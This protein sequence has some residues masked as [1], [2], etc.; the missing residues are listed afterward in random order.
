M[1]RAFV[2]VAACVG[3]V[4]GGAGCAPG[5]AFEARPLGRAIAE[6]ATVAGTS[7]GDLW[8]VLSRDEAGPIAIGHVGRD[9][10]WEPL[11]IR[12]V[13]GVLAMASPGPDETWVLTRATASGVPA[14][15]QVKPGGVVTDHTAELGTNIGP[16]FASLATLG[17]GGGGVFVTVSTEES[18]PRARILRAVDGR[19]VELTG[20]PM[21]AAALVVGVVGP[22]EAYFALDSRARIVRWA[23]GVWS[24]VPWTAPG[25]PSVVAAAPTG[26]VWLW[27]PG[28]DGSG[29]AGL[30][31][32]GTTFTPFSVAGWPSR[33]AVRYD[34]GT[35]VPLG[36]G[37]AAILAARS[38][39]RRVEL[40][41]VAISSDG[42]VTGDRRLASCPSVEACTFEPPAVLRFSDGTVILANTSTLFVGATFSL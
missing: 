29:G 21:A 38:E 5:E 34:A 39:A 36:G 16:T 3:V 24:D 37:R 9:Q 6:P 27:R 13:G 17:A 18:I 42:R 35:L 28:S 25:G 19:L 33:D 20:A 12:G 40:D 11:T 2:V 1:G 7:L 41:S 14:V 30:F 10:T 22:D 26:E 23:G 15:L 31:G 32:D 4:A 8:A